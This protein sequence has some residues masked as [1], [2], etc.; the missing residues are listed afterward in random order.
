MIVFAIAILFFLF[1]PPLFGFMAAPYSR[2]SFLRPLSLIERPYEPILLKITREEMPVRAEG[3]IR[4]I[5]LP[6][7]GCQTMPDEVQIEHGEDARGPYINI[8][9]RFRYRVRFEGETIVSP[10]IPSQTDINE[11]VFP[12]KGIVPEFGALPKYLASRDRWG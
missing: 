9:G 6:L 12:Q 7:A 4:D 8:A 1:N 2:I 10:V 5:V 11:I 3:F